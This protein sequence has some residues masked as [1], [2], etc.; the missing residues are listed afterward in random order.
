MV[1]WNKKMNTKKYVEFWNNLQSQ[2]SCNGEKKTNIKWREDVEATG[3][4][5]ETFE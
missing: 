4:K 2:M 5:H 3:Q 1:K